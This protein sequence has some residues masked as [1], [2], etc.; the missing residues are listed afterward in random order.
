MFHRI[1][2]D[3][4]PYLRSWR[5][6]DT[7]EPGKI[8]GSNQAG[9]R[10]MKSWLPG[11][12]LMPQ[13]TSWTLRRCGESAFGNRLTIE[14]R[15]QVQSEK[16]I[17]FC[18]RHRFFGMIM[19]KLMPCSKSTKM[20]SRQRRRWISSRLTSPAGMPIKSASTGTAVA[21]ASEAALLCAVHR[22]PDRVRMRRSETLSTWAEEPSTR[23]LV[24][25]RRV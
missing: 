18:P 9:S 4:S 22:M 2:V 13:L 7:I 10:Q 19:E 17:G 6:P 1:L 23:Y 16:R 11:N 3:C 15:G 8:Y 25:M 20:E 21:G 12:I 24:E 5:P 14:V